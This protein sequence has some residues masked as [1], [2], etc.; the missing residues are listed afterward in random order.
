MKKSF[1]L[2]ACCLAGSFLVSA[3]PVKHVVV[4]TVDGFRPDFYLD[5]SWRAVHIRELMAAAIESASVPLDPDAQGK[6]V[7]RAVQ[8]KQR[9]RRPE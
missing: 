6:L 7:I 3:Q 4:I 5:S 8:P 9:P 2:A 1:F